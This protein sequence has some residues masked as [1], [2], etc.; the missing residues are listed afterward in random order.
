MRQNI[1]LSI[2]RLV[3]T[4][5]VA[6]SVALGV[7]LAEIGTPTVA[8]AQSDFVPLDR[9]GN[10]VAGLRVVL[11]VHLRGQSLADALRAVVRAAGLD[12]V[13]PSD[14]PAMSALVTV[15]SDTLPASALLLRLVDGTGVELLV[16]PRGRTL[17]ARQRAGAGDARRPGIGRPVHGS[18]RDST[19]GTPIPDALVVLE[20]L[21]GRVIARARTGEDGR[22]Q[23]QDAPSTLLVVRA[24]RVGFAAG[25]DTVSADGPAEMAL[26]LA[27]AASTLST[28]VVTP[29][30][31]G[32][33]EQQ[34]AARQT[35]TREQL[36]AAPQLGED[37]LRSVNRLPG[38]SASDFSAAFRVR[39]GANDELYMSLDGLELVEPFHLKDFDGAFS[40][41]D[42]G[43]VEGLDLTT[44]GFDA[45][46]GNRLT[47]VVTMRT[48]EPPPS[49]PRLT[50]I[51]LTLSTVRATSSGSFAGEGV[52][53]CSQRGAAFSSTRSAPP[54]R[55]TTSGRGTTTS[56][57]KAPTVLARTRSS[58]FI[59]CTLATSSHTRT[60]WR[61]PDSK[62]NTRAPMRGRLSRRSRAS[63]CRSAR[64]PRSGDSLGRVRVLGSRSSTARRTSA[65]T[66]TVAIAS[67]DCDRTGSGSSV[68]GWW[69]SAVKRVPRM[70][71]MP[72]TA[73]SV[74]SRLWGALRYRWKRR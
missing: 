59:C 44:G 41:I 9:D 61:S 57:Q 73:S 48:L 58:R 5:L 30:F 56:S 68:D 39:S 38:V 18:V 74:S 62:A 32:V 31:Y 35:L 15:D 2:A 54:A 65:S 25:M 71:R 40:I 69:D 51:A 21:T 1:S 64:S 17:A 23:V 50:E 67:A 22:F 7:A 13:A 6:L 28:V 37:L 46:V 11:S 29:G 20:N 27:A 53:G 66:T 72:T 14:L 19:T 36:R 43:A 49:T 8:C 16:S 60:T 26:T 52:A 33:M 63:T 45:R 3:R 70:L 10:G 55:T 12:L 47:G 24:R 34:L 42:V 4:M